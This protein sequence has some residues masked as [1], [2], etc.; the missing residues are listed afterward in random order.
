MSHEAPPRSARSSRGTDTCPV[1]MA[2][3][4]MPDCKCWSWAGPTGRVHP[5]AGLNGKYAREG[6][7]PSGI[8]GA[9]D[10][11]DD[12]GA[13]CEVAVQVRGH[14]SSPRNSA[15]GGGQCGTYLDQNDTIWGKQR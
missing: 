13:A 4:A 15:D 5:S 14:A 7:L 3:D 1:G 9:V 2:I 12:P 6:L 11:F 8:L 10:K